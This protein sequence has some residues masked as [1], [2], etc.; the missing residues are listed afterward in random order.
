M[1]G[2]E[3]F[4]R[5]GAA[6]LRGACHEWGDARPDRAWACI[7]C[8]GG[9]ARARYRYQPHTMR[10]L[11]AVAYLTNELQVRKERLGRAVR[12]LRCLFAL[13][14]WLGWMYLMAMINVALFAIFLGSTMIIGGIY[15]PAESGRDHPAGA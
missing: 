8:Y 11:R 12:T 9:F 13:C 14:V 5:W 6:R 10:A 7:D 15:I 3:Q 4:V 2:I 1:D